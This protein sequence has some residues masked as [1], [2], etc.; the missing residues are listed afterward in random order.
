MALELLQGKHEQASLALALAWQKQLLLR[1][2]VK[3]RKA[4]RYELQ[5][6]SQLP[7]RQQ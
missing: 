7:P 4:L 2:S 6:A 1:T 3:E 5:D